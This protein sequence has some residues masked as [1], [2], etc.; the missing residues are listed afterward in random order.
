M[1]LFNNI[2][3]KN[4]ESQVIENKT[5]G[6]QEGKSV[7]TVPLPYAQLL[8]SAG[9]HDLW[10]NQALVYYRQ[11]APLFT[12]VERIADE[13]AKIKPCLWDKRKKEFV[14]DDA[15][16]EFLERPFA[17]IT[18]QEFIKEFAV[19]LIVTGNNYT[20]LRGNVKYE[21]IEMLNIHPATISLI[22]N[23][24]DT[25][26]EIIN[27]NAT[28]YLDAFRRDEKM[29]K[30]QWRFVNGL[31]FA[32]I[33]Q[34]RTLNTRFLGASGRYGMSILT[35]IYYEIEQHILGAVHNRALL[36][37]GARLSALFSV[38]QQLSMDSYNRFVE[39]L[40]TQYQGA[41]NAG[42][43]LLGEGGLK[44]TELGMN[45]KDMDYI[46]LNKTNIIQI[47]N[48]LKVPLALVSPDH[49]TYDNV[50]KAILLLYFNAV[51]PW[52]ERIYAELS[53][54]LLPR[55]G[56]TENLEI[57]YQIDKIPA[58]ATYRMEIAKAK[59]DLGAYSPNE[60]RAMLGDKLV[61]GLSEVTG[62]ANVV[63]LG[64]TEELKALAEFVD[65]MT[66]QKNE[67]GDPMFSS[68]EIKDMMGQYGF[69]Q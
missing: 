7:S 56:E 37:N 8:T 66:R 2:F 12:A 61:E 13:I 11:C 55:F 33:W 19:F 3:R 14:E 26:N 38:D 45:N 35:P 57:S 58:L 30:R 9:W 59:K 53:M 41:N 69:R 24:Y 68:D 63:P 29:I 46:N 28:P 47:Y 25:Y 1:K 50:A 43:F 60:I 44:V 27:V 15:I 20:V 17:D 51:L 65:V 42:K 32:E 31:R 54:F 10:P 21:P 34:S 22:A 62:P 5:V 52:I 18:F 64:N 48:T 4:N 36:T 39:Q 49:T 67:N 6:A 16:C 40:A 23:P